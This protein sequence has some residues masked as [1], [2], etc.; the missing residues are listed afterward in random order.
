MY[1]TEM[2]VCDCLCC[3]TS[4]AGKG[5]NSQISCFWSA[6][7]TQSYI[8][9]SITN[10]CC[11]A[12]PFTYQPGQEG[13]VKAQK[14]A[15]PLRCSDWEI[16][17]SKHNLAVNHKY[18]EKST[19]RKWLDIPWFTWISSSCE[20]GLIFGFECRNS[21]EQ[22]LAFQST[23]NKSSAALAE[24]QEVAPPCPQK[25]FLGHFLLSSTFFGTP[26]II[27]HRRMHRSD[28]LFWH[29]V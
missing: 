6:S 20:A 24:I 19:W 26:D 15:M 13:R 2:M 5:L 11:V 27:L 25:S 9:Q 17:E 21:I 8:T 18:E 4:V 12:L 3:S 22:L 28:W 10:L 29:S 16:H 1:V 7:P 23:I 14:Y